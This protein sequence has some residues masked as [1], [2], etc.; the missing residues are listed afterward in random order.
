LLG[1]APRSRSSLPVHTIVPPPWPC[2]AA[3]PRPAPLAS[4][5]RSNFSETGNFGFGIEEHI[6][7]G[8]KYDPGIGIFGMDFFVVMGRPGFRVARR[9]HA[10]GRVG[11]SHRVKPEQT[12]AWFKQRFDGIVSR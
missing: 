8:I 4:L 6:D 3:S 2:H 10:K 9:K 12:V 5:T 11:F 1:P 7:L